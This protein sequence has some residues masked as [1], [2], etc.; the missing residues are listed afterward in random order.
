MSDLPPREPLFNGGS[1]LS[2]ATSPG[3]G[4]CRL[5]AYRAVALSAYAQSMPLASVAGRF[6]AADVALDRARRDVRHLDALTFGLAGAEPACDRYPEVSHA[7][8]N[9]LVW[10]RMVGVTINGAGRA[11]G[12]PLAFAQWWSSIGHNAIHAFFRTSRNEA[13][14]DV[15]DLIVESP[16]RLDFGHTL[17]FFA[18]DRGRFEGE[19]LVARCQQYTEWLYDACLAPAR[20]HLWDWDRGRFLDGSEAVAVEGFWPPRHVATGAP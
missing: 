13:L 9:W 17:A 12:N 5:L 8:A 7:Y 2:G 4:F 10:A 19:P 6:V 18:F 20:E 3:F 15:A 1:G 14:K 11:A 16:L